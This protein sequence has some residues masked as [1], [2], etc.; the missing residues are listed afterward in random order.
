MAQRLS[1]LLNK[2]PAMRQAQA[3]SALQKQFDAVLPARF[4]GEAVVVALEEG[5]LRVLCSNGAIASRL[6]LEAQS[7]AAALQNKGMAV[8]RVSLK[9]QPANL[10]TTSAPRAKASLPA[11]ARQAFA[12]ASEQLDE[13]EV[14]A[15]LQRLL[16]RH[17]PGR[18]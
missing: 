17:Q 1:E 2:L 6:R 13:G 12:S 18:Q 15:A 16:R 8:R 5:E 11:A 3:L 4:R 9:V 7:L 10:R 14:K